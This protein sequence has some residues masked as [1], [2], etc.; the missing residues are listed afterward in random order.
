MVP[1]A[2]QRPRP[3]PRDPLVVKN[4]W[5]M[6][7]R[8]AAEIPVPS[9]STVT[10]TIPCATRAAMVTAPPSGIASRALRSRLTKQR[11]LR[12][13]TTHQRQLGDFSLDA[14]G[15]RALAQL[16]LGERHCLVD[17]LAQVHGHGRDRT[18]AREVV[19]LT[20]DPRRDFDPAGHTGERSLGPAVDRGDLEAR[21]PQRVPQI[22]RHCC[23]ELAEHAQSLALRERLPGVRELQIAP[24]FLADVVEDDDDVGRAPLR[25]LRFHRDVEVVPF[26]S[27]D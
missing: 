13:G 20:H 24:R 10:S 6:R 1:F 15:R 18:L 21:S 17:D 9:S 14:D 7:G 8:T 2:S 27:E 16:D 5:K 25:L 19:E 3:A 4:G 12:R 26:G 23:R 22:V 11:Q